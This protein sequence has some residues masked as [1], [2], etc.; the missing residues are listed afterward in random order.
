MTCIT[1]LHENPAVIHQNTAPPRS[2]YL[3]SPA[4]APVYAQRK[5]DT[6]SCLPLNGE[7]DFKF[8]DCPEQAWESGLFADSGWAKLPVPG[9][10]QLNGYDRCQYVN[11]QYP[12]PYDPP[13]VPHAN[14]AGMYRRAF[15]VTAEQLAGRV[16]INFEGVDSCYYLFVNG[17]YVGY[18]E[19]THA[20]GE[21]DITAFC[22]A[23]GNMLTVLV[24]K[25]CA[26][27]YFEDQDKFRF[28]GIIRDVYLLF[29]PKNHIRDYEIKTAF[30]E[31]YATADI[32]VSLDFQGTPA[33][34]QYTF[35]DA[36]GNLISSSQDGR[37]QLKNPRLWNAEAPYLYTLTM[38]CGG[39]AICVR[40]GL[41]EVS[42]KDGVLL[43]NGQK[44]KFRGVNRHD[45]D[46]FVGSALDA[47]HIRRDLLIMKRHNINAIRT[48][49]YPSAPVFYELCDQYGFYVIDEADLECHGTETLHGGEGD[50]SKLTDD[51]FWEGYVTDRIRR[52]V[53]RDKNR[54]CAVIWSMGNE[55]GFG[56]NIQAAL[57]WT[58]K[59]DPSRPT[60]Y[61]S[62]RRGREH[63]TPDMPDTADVDFYSRM[64]PPLHEIHDYFAN[65]YHR[66]KKPMVLCEYAH[67]MGNGPGD[68]EDYF[69]IIQQYDGLCGAF[70]WEWTDHAVFGGNTADGKL[71][72]LYGGDSGEF[73]DDG[74]F[75]MDGL[76]YPDRRPH[77]G[78]LELK[79][80]QRPLRFSLDGSQLTIHN[81][82]DFTHSAAYVEID[83]QIMRGGEV[84]GS[85]SPAEGW[86]D[87]PPHGSVT[88]TVD[89]PL[90]EEG[91][92]HLLINTRR[93]AASETV[94]VGHSLGVDQL[95]ICDTQPDA[96]VAADG[97]APEWEQTAFGV[98]IKGDGFRYEIDRFTGLFRAL[99][100]RGEAVLQKPMVFQLWRAPVDNDRYIVGDWH[101]ARYN[102]IVPYVYEMVAETTGSAV[103][104]TAKL[105]LTAVSRQ[106]AAAVTVV[107]RIGGDGKIYCRME[108]QKS[109][110]Y[111]MWPRFGI[112]MFLADED[113][114]VKYWGYGPNESYCD[115]HRSC[116][117]GKFDTTA[118]ALHEDY[119]RPQENG[120]RW[121]C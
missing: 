47:E 33:P 100:R 37:C 78:L 80:V 32:T 59:R 12:F 119:L 50:A 99:E 30:S 61:E 18:D 87:L 26:G 40:L 116:W 85:W 19:V 55:A 120:S 121:G 84:S 43:I 66:A 79:N 44:I 93:K 20:A 5:E 91:Y 70:V 39:E 106:P 118:A 114:A 14:P 94:P 7:W 98:T 75:C 71:K 11:I 17:A 68:L 92:C 103:E 4:S 53:E 28:T 49:H 13:H 10:W 112:Q 45:S 117:F 97:P 82:L 29:R 46:P 107:W 31:G 67:A 96:A 52:M 24:L 110:A 109:P 6:P 60:H 8:F 56:R 48:S 21:F 2:Y 115:K 77:T 89:T 90:P 62:R 23:G 108:V 3:P 15:S 16:Y 42:I 34:V 111:D 22:R 69:Q 76:V 27:S 64:Y 104:V 102:H 51:P 65:A 83:C 101:H 105:A 113:H 54:P 95:L 35:T 1:W 81:Y 88:V 72:F 63:L 57:R 86:P 25:F 58:K 9:I 73:P 74:N 41:R 38:T 36:D